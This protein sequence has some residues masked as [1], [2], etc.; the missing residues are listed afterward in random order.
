MAVKT[1]PL[2]VAD[3]K[4]LIVE[5]GKVDD[6]GNRSVHDSAVAKIYEAGGIDAATRSTVHGIQQNLV[7]AAVGL[8]QEDLA[9]KVK[10]AKEGGASA[11]ALRAIVGPET[12]IVDGARFYVEASAYKQRRDPTTGNPI[13]RFSVVKLTVGTKQ[14]IRQ[15]YSSD[16]AAEMESLLAS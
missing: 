16:A 6:K 9:A 10:A 12:T 3:C 11:E 15:G 5:H 13:D 4:K 7:A 14:L 8:S 1:S 2:S